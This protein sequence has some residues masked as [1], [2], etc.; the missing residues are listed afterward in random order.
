MKSFFAI[1]FFLFLFAAGCQKPYDISD[2]PTAKN[3]NASGDTT[4]IQKGAWTG[5]NKPEGIVYGRDQLFYV[6]DT[7]NNRIVMLN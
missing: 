4:Y 5:F 2:L 1:L 7:R 6:M 3:I